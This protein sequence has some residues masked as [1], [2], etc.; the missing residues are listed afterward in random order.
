MGAEGVLDAVRDVRE[1]DVTG[2]EVLD[3][4]FVGRREDRRVSAAAAPRLKGEGEARVL[5][6]VRLC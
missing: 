1:A 2:E 4:D 5:L 3:G 6:R